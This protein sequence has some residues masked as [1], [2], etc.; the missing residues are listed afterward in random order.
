[1][2]FNPW[3]FGIIW[4]QPRRWLNKG[5]ESRRLPKGR[6]KK[7]L[8]IPR[9]IAGAIVLWSTD[10]HGYSMFEGVSKVWIKSHFN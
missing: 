4:K 9:M 5:S 3:T 7:D 6:D 1:M 10:F 2:G 8:R